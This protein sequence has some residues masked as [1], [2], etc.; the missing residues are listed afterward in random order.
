MR[1]TEKV[2]S[3]HEPNRNCKIHKRKSLQGF[4]APRSQLHIKAGLTVVTVVKLC[5]TLAAKLSSIIHMVLV[6]GTRKMKIVGF[7]NSSC[8]VSVIT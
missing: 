8:V 7:V 3:R 4:S 1:K 6:W 2:P 5:P